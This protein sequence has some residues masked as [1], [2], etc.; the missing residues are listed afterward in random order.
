MAAG[1]DKIGRRGNESGLVIIDPSLWSESTASVACF[2]PC[3]YVLLP[4]T[5]EADT[6]FIYPTLTTEIVLGTMFPTSY[7]Y[8]GNVTPT[9]LWKGI[10][11]TMTV[12]IPPI[13]TSVLLF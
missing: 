3:T 9:T 2:D 12:V 7:T 10:T 5:L 4:L 11:T 1:R 13:T 6:I 8:L